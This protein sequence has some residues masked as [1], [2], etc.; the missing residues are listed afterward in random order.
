LIALR[1]SPFWFVTGC[2][3]FGVLGIGH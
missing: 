2:D 1:D 3:I